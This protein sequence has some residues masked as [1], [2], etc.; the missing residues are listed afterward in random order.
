MRECD[1]DNGRSIAILQ[2]TPEE[3]RE[4]LGAP[5]AMNYGQFKEKVLKKAVE[6][7]NLKID[8]MDLEIF[9]GSLW[10]ES[11]SS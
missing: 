6:E 7:I 5:K 4:W 9:Q 8:D 11:C 1:R 10:S 2:G 3:F